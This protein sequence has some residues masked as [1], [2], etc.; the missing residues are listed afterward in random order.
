MFM[1]RNDNWIQTYSG[2]RF[3]PTD[4]RIEDIKI[5]DI[6]AAL[7]K[8]CRYA[9]HCHKFYSVAE[10]SILVSRHVPF[11]FRLDALLHD[12]AEAYLVDIPTPLKAAL[13]EYKKYENAIMELIACK[14]NFQWPMTHEIKEIDRKILIDEI[15]QNMAPMQYERIPDERG[16]GLGVK[17]QLWSPDRSYYEFLAAFFEYGG[18]G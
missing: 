4:P 7:S 1:R 13:P 10:H 6:A 9:G 12:A 16:P 2:H 8:L 18:K 15:T 17:L 11:R 5:I 14:F 3:W